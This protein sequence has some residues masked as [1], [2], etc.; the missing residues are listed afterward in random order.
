MSYSDK[1]FWNDV[2]SEPYHG[3]TDAYTILNATLGVKFADGKATF[4]LR[5]TNLLNQEIL[6]H[7]YGDITRRSI[8]AEL[9][10]FAK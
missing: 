9:S 5:G 10:Y 3:Y 4:S 1:A 2:L 7:I 6:Q 8:M